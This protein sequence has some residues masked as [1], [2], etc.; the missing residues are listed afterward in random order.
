MC[1]VFCHM[2]NS[3]P[4]EASMVH[5]YESPFFNATFSKNLFFSRNIRSDK[6]YIKIFDKKKE[7]KK[8]RQISKFAWIVLPQ[9]I[10][11]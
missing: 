3:N 10:I 2:I 1:D 11:F 7:R 9:M 4:F 6:R 8:N 5:K